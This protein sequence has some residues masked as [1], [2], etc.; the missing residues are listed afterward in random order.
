MRFYEKKPDKGSNYYRKSFAW[1]PTGVGN[2]TVW[3]EYYWE[4]MFWSTEYKKYRSAG[5]LGVYNLL[6][7][8]YKGD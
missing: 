4:Y 2:T 7:E 1:F 8:E 6:A 5:F 3:L